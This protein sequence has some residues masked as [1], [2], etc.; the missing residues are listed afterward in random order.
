MVE[1]DVLEPEEYH[2]MLRDLRDGRGGGRDA[3]SQSTTEV[4]ETAPNTNV[5]FG[6]QFDHMVVTPSGAELPVLTQQEA[7]YYD[8]RAER[9]LQDHKFT[10]ITDLQDL[11][12]ILSSE[13]TLYRYDIWLALAK[14]Y[15]G[16]SVSEDKLLRYIK[17]LSK[18]LMDLKK[19]MGLD[20]STRDKDQG[21]DFVSWLEDTRR[22][23]KAFMIM[24]NEQFFA[25]ITLFNEVIGR[26]Q[27]YRNADE[28][29]RKELGLEPEQVLDWLWDDVFPRFNA[30]DEHF[31]NEG[32][33]AQKYWTE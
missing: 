13:L 21:A 6:D 3:A 19:S 15:F 10:S 22:R 25:S 7:D 17:D 32:P 11:D 14:D 30:I 26:V 28:V 16:N 8:S 4:P 18:S 20:K 27:T 2:E 1:E 5:A 31:K 29:E 9:Y 33:N 24:R 12:R 23:A